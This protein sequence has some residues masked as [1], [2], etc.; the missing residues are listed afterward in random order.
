LKSVWNSFG[1]RANS[2]SNENTTVPTDL[3]EA[4]C[5]VIRCDRCFRPVVLNRRSAKQPGFVCM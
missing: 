4:L 3:D 1:C 5:Q 2:Q